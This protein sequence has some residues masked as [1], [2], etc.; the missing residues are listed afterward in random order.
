MTNT[1]Y[2]T[3]TV[4]TD[5]IK[6]KDHFRDPIALKR[7]KRRRKVDTANPIFSRINV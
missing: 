5:T 4:R 3:A 6:E 7:S 2:E 1:K